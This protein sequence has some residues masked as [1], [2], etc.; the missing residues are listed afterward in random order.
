MGRRFDEKLELCKLIRS[1]REILFGK[2][3]EGN[4]TKEAKELTWKWIYNECA[5]KG[6]SWTVGKDWCYLRRSKWPVIKCEAL[7]GLVSKLPISKIAN[8]E[9]FKSRSSIRRSDQENY[10]IRRIHLR[11]CPNARTGLSLRIRRS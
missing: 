4:S 6:H 1:Q 9:A 11:I 3:G 8:S 2:T 10:E 7:V 5:T